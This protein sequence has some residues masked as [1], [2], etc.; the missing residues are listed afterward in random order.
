MEKD[1]QA[2]RGDQGQGEFLPA[3][4]APSACT[5]LGCGWLLVLQTSPQPTAADGVCPEGWR[6]PRSRWTDGSKPAKH[7]VVGPCVPVQPQGVRAGGAQ[8]CP[9]TAAALGAGR[10]LGA[11]L[12]REPRELGCTLGDPLTFSSFW[13]RKGRAWRGG[14]GVS[15]R[16]LGSSAGLGWGLRVRAAARLCSYTNGYTLT[17]VPAPAITPFQCQHRALAVEMNHWPCPRRG[18]ASAPGSSLLLWASG[19][20]RPSRAAHGDRPGAGLC[21]PLLG[22]VKVP[23]REQNGVS[24]PAPAPYALGIARPS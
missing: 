13:P 3:F 7:H 17:G 21:R 22:P 10:T 1:L 5:D 16:R 2:G 14:G 6:W 4:S 11:K 9:F 23:R 8:L 20:W 24:V 19:W 12:L 15:C 18:R